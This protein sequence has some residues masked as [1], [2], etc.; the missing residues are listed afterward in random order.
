MADAQSYHDGL[1]AQGYPADQA[2]AY[3]RQYYPDFTPAVSAPVAAAPAA[4]Q[5]VQPCLLYTSDAA[6]E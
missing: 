1:V 6:D 4:P 3:T 2:L 5:P